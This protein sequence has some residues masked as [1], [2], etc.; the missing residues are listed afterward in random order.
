[1][2]IGTKSVMFRQQS[3]NP[4]PMSPPVLPPWPQRVQS[5]LTI[6]IWKNP[7]GSLYLDNLSVQ[8][9]S[10]MSGSCA[11]YMP[12]GGQNLFANSNFEAGTTNW[13]AYHSGLQLTSNAHSG[14]QAIYLGSGSGSIAQAEEVASAGVIYTARGMFQRPAGS[15]WSGIGIDFFDANWN[16]IS[17]VYVGI[18]ETTNYAPTTVSGI[19]PAGTEHVSVWIWKNSGGH[20]YIDDVSLVAGDVANANIQSTAADQ[21]WSVPSPLNGQGV[22]VAVVDSGIANH[23]DLNQ[24]GTNTSRVLHSID[25]T[26]NGTTNDINGHGTHVA[27]IIAGNGTM[28]NGIHRGIAP[29]ANLINVRISN[30]Q[31]MTYSSELVDGL[32]WIFDNKDTHN[33]RIVNISLNSTVAE[34]YHTGPINA[35]VELLWFSGITVVVS[36]GNNGTAGGSSTLYPPAND[37]FVITV[38]ATSDRN[39]SYLDDDFVESFSAYGTTIEGHAKPDLVAPGRN[40]IS[41]SAGNN[42]NLAQNHPSHKSGSY[43]FRMSGTSMAAP[44]VSGVIALLLQDEPALTPDQIKYRLKAT[45]STN[46]PGYDAAK[47]GAGH[48]NAY[49]AVHG[50]TT[51][52]ANTGI[53][54]SQMLW[55]GEDPV[56]W[57]SV[58]WNS[59]SWNSVSWN[60]VSWNSVSWNSVSWNSVIMLSSLW[61]DIFDDRLLTVTEW[62]ATTT[63]ASSNE[64]YLPMI[65][66]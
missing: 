1:M 2:P 17:D 55:T 65:S 18:P 59:V 54:A 58:S 16:E 25:L 38:G 40:I 29:A 28:A 48:V 57:D 30:G 10:L 34:S 49:A 11:G 62:D 35:A 22:T 14:S 39:T 32:Q 5:H 50:T 33:I 27:G 47:A 21:L 26:N 61:D 44:T 3:L 63:D 36:A 53:A 42:S 45:A 8:S 9:S 24:A 20:L 19:A 46:W 66:R 31:G 37:P 60:S 13:D 64:I 4:A 7:G 51:A 23:S 52:T 12:T 56:A 43:Y 6:W 41:L 15:P